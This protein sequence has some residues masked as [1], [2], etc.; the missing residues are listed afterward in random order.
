MKKRSFEELV[1]LKQSGKIGWVE[2]LQQGEYAEAYT[3]WLADR[4][5]EADEENA[6]LFLD[7]TDA[8]F[9]DSQQ[10]YHD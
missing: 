8:A 9:Q 3:Q 6:E 2:F 5:E 1:Q 10:N 7:Q 4:N